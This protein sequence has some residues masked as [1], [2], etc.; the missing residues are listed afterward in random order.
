M[1]KTID[2]KT[3]HGSGLTG[4][5]AEPEENNGAGILL[6]QEIF[7]VNSHIRDV[8]DLYAAAGYTVLAPD[9]FWRAEPKI[10]LGYSPEDMQKGMA[11][12][13]KLDKEQMLQDLLDAITTLKAQPG[14]GKVAAVGYCMGGTFSFRLAAKGAVD[15]AVCYYGG[16]IS[17]VLSEAANIKGPI[18]LHFGDQDKHIPAEVVSQIANALK[19][20]KQAQV[21]T[22]HAD[23]G[24]NCDQRGSYNRFAA[25]LAYG[26][27]SVF[28]NR[29]LA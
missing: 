14:C 27:T 4:Y 8:A 24:F 13:G 1:S 3:S 9:V 20:H 2:I 6:I 18:M 11:I 16:Q 26:R 17:Q 10:E 22:Y 15:A 12:V 19:G 28:L 21:L 25:M 7:G 5:L 23:H 29:S